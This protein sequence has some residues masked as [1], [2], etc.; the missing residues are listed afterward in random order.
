MY[1]PHIIVCNINISFT[2]PRAIENT[3]AHKYFLFST[4]KKN[5]KSIGIDR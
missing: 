1:R 2:N 3:A 5:P 4:A